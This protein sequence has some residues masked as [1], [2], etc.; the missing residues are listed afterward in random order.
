MER[1]WQNA[2]RGMALCQEDSSARR[3]AVIFARR[4]GKVSPFLMQRW[5]EI[6][7][8]GHL[9][10]VALLHNTRF[11][12]NLTEK[13][14]SWWDQLLQSAPFAPVLGA[15]RTE[16]TTPAGGQSKKNEFSAMTLEQFDHIC[17]A[18]AAVAGVKKV[19][20]F[21]ANAVLPW[22]QEERHPIPLP[23]VTPSR[24]LEVSVGDDRLDTL[25]DGANG[26]LSAFDETF[27]VYAHGVGLASF[28]A[29]M[30]WQHR[31]RVRQ[32]PTSGVEIIVPHPHDLIFSKLVAGRP[33]DF[34]FAT[35]L[36]PVFPI[37][38][39]VQLELVKEFEAAHPEHVQSL[40]ENLLR[41]QA[42]LK[43][44]LPPKS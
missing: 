34:E 41:W 8:G 27:S 12:L 37:A 16:R 38:E 5:I 20:V 23:N 17:R 43:Q 9:E 32:E 29:P 2:R 40:S 31:A 7:N 15:Q 36:A 42:H 22:L 39:L 14:R 18:A 11:F 35:A 19:Y 1:A 33:K 4:A 21:G 13:E 30:H 10:H 25:I 24:E 28:H 26:E 6:L 3:K 44:K